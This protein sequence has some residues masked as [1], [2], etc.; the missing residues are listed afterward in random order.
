MDFSHGHNVSLSAVSECLLAVEEIFRNS[1]AHKL[2]FPKKPGSN[3]GGGVPIFPTLGYFKSEV[4][5]QLL[6]RWE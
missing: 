6:L 3:G 4:L 2:S 5:N 1:N